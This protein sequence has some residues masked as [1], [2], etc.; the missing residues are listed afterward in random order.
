MWSL[1]LLRSKIFSNV[2]SNWDDWGQVY[3]SI[4]AFNSLA[5]EILRREKLPTAELSLLFPGTNAVFKAG[6]YVL[7]IYAPAETGIDQT[8]DMQTEIF[9]M[10]RANEL[11]V[12]APRLAADG[13]IEDKYTFAYIITEYAGGIMF[14]NAIKQM[15]DG[16][17]LAF[18]ARQREITDILNTPCQPFNDIEPVNGAG[19]FKRWET[20]SDSFKASRKR[21]IAGTFGDNTVNQRTDT[22][23]ADTVNRY[24]GRQS[25]IDKS[26]CEPQLDLQC[27]FVH[28]DLCGDNILISPSGDIRIIDF[29][30]AVL[31]PV[32]YEHALLPFEFKW[33]SHLMRGYFGDYDTDALAEE[34]LCGI[35]IH[36]FGGDIVKSGI[37]SSQSFTSVDELRKAISK[38]LETVIK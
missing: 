34:I 36:D 37:P 32:C 17:K 13:F 20:Y 11:G 9:S 3:Q 30:D 15:T 28:G 24:D 2:L 22:L 12:A 26:F 5:Q 31:A 35:L 33:D 16:A 21:Y 7:K 25:D 23:I 14:T 10:K 4:P 18:G 27:V 8:A 38:R 29:A 6:A 1:K 19:R